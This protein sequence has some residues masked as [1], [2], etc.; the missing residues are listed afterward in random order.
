MGF[1]CDELP[2]VGPVPGSVNTYVAA[3][4]HGHGLGYA[5]IAAKA[6]TEM[7]LDGTSSIPGDLL[8]PRRHLQE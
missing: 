7:M 2:T 5:V 8:S 6:V 1:S 4:Y 3:G